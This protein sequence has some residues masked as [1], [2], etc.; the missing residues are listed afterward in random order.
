MTRHYFGGALPDWTFTTTTVSST[1][2][3]AQLVGG[4]TITMWNAETGGAQYTDLQTTG[5]AATDYAS[6]SDGTDGRALGTIVPFYG[7]DEV[8]VMW[9]SADGGP[10]ALIVSSD[11]GSIVGPLVD[12]LNAQLG[13]HLASTG[14]PHANSY[15]TLTDVSTTAPTNGQ[16]PVYDSTAAKWTP[17]SPAG[18]NAGDFVATA[19]GSTIRVP[20]GDVTTQA[21]L[22]RVPDGDRTTANA[23]DTL[24]VE[25]NAGTAGTP[26]WRRTGWF[27]EFGELRSQASAASRIPFR[28]KQRDGTQTG[29]LTQWTDNANNPLAWVAANGEVRG[30]NVMYAPWLFSKSGSFTTGTGAFRVYNDTGRTL[31]I[32]SVRAS[33]GTVPTTAVIVDINKNG[34][35]IFSTQ[36]NRPQIAIGANTSG[37]VTAINTT[38]IADGEYLTVDVDQTAGAADLV[39]QIAVY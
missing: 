36:A 14:N 21:L 16:I 24:S 27:N 9:A 25:W 3:L 8:Y 6:T 39:V 10:R 32:R 12:T 37:K 17:G 15:A 13:A 20:D 31:T 30:S 26:N 2:N 34:T 33:V 5:G 23:P 35:T 29:D 22:L 19:G 1:D 7:P 4:A 18:I 28:V 38:T 11:V